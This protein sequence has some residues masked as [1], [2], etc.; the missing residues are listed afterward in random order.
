MYNISFQLNGNLDDTKHG[1][2]QWALTDNLQEKV[3]SFYV[4]HMPTS[5]IL[6]LIVTITPGPD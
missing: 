2:S 3:K 1:R 6:G 4:V 5:P